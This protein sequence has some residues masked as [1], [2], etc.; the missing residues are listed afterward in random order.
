MFLLLCQSIV[1][2]VPLM[3]FYRN[4]GLSRSF[5]GIINV[6]LFALHNINQSAAPVQAA[7]LT[8]VSLLGFGSIHPPCEMPGTTAHVVLVLLWAGCRCCIVG[9]TVIERGWHCLVVALVNDTDHMSHALRCDGKLVGTRGFIHFPVKFPFPPQ[10]VLRGGGQ[11]KD[12]LAPV[13]KR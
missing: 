13:P 9:S 5:M 4:Y 3:I 11:H 12:V 10:T 2:L 1:L 6:N 7:G 8:C